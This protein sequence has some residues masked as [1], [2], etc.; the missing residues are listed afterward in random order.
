MI[1]IQND[2]CWRQSRESITEF[3]NSAAVSDAMAAVSC[4]FKL[5]H[6]RVH[7]ICCFHTTQIPVAARS[8]VWACGNS[9]DGIAGSNPAGGNGCPCLV[10]VVWQTSLRLADHSSREVLLNAVC[11]CVVVKPR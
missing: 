3:F 7:F 9:L 11:L 8:K 6:I 10:S 1:G 2:E 4:L 5:C